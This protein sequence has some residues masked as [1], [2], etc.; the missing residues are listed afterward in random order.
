M[1]IFRTVT[2]LILALVEGAS[3]QLP[4][5]LSPPSAPPTPAEAPTVSGGTGGFRLRT[6]VN[7]VVVEA[8]VRDQGGGIVNDLAQENF[9]IYEDGVEQQIRY[10]SRYELPLAIALVVDASGSM[11]PALR[12]LHRVAYDNL[13]AL[14]PDD[15]VALFEFAARSKLRVGLTRNRRS[16]ADGV[17]DIRPGG[18]TVIPDALFEAAL[19][20]AKTAPDRRHDIILVSDNENTLQ[21]YTDEK[22]VIREALESEAVIYSIQVE[23]EQH[24][25]SMVVLLPIFRDVSVAKIVHETGGEVIAAKSVES[26]GSAMATAISR[27]KE[28]YSLSYYSTNGRLDGGFRE[29][30]IRVTDGSKDSGRRYVAYAR[31]GYYARTEGTSSLNPCTGPGKQLASFLLGL[32]FLPQGC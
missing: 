10:F 19:Y 31:R 23:Q 20:L 7:L 15:R 18:A 14:K 25:H 32:S 6:D 3:G 30:E 24:P 2:V 27:L 5:S 26:I 16:I 21:G 11:G 22:R 9:H 29:I 28:R 17:A 4:P 8:T 13:S 12:Q 1:T